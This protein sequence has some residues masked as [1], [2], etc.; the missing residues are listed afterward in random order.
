MT[1]SVDDADF[2]ELMQDMEKGLA[3]MTTSVDQL[4][5][6]LAAS[7]RVHELAV[8]EPKVVQLLTDRDLQQGQLRIMRDMQQVL[9]ELNMAMRQPEAREQLLAHAST[10]TLKRAAPR[11]VA[12]V[13]RA[14]PQKVSSGDKLYG[15]FPGEQGKLASGIAIKKGDIGTTF[16]PGIA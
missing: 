14:A 16:P 2:E 15:T 8:H 4:Q 13:K 12:S 5:A 3:G 11:K 10:K 6:T 9:H 1:T 7:P